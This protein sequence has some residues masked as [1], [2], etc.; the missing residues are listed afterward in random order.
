MALGSR[1]CAALRRLGEPNKQ[2]STVHGRRPP[3]IRLDWLKDSQGDIRVSV[4]DS[5]IGISPAYHDQIFGMFKRLESRR[6]FEGT[7]AG[8]AICQK[9]IQRHHGR[10]G[11][12]S[13]RGEGATFWFALPE[14][15][16]EGDQ[17]Q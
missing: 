14:A 8:L 4:A 2:C 10:I 3:K 11:V 5:G 13:V 9:V 12:E 1:E 15:T 16:I 17:Q 7:G 6:T